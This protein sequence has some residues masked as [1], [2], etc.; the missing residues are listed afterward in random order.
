MVVILVGES[1]IDP[2]GRE[3]LWY[4]ETAPKILDDILHWHELRF[5]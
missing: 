2:E 5:A 1:V 4:A 3:L